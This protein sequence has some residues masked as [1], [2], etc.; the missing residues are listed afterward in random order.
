[1][2]RPWLGAAFSPFSASSR[3]VG[4]V[5][6]TASTRPFHFIRSPPKFSTDHFRLASGS[7]TRRWMW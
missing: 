6:L 5:Y 7:A 1:M 4:F 3:T 2:A